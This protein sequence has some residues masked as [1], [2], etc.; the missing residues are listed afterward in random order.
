MKL[1]NE[2]ELDVSVWTIQRHLRRSGLRYKKIPPQIYLTKKHKENRVST[3]S[4][5]VTENYPWEKNR[6]P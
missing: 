2:C 4:T 3:I 1:K 5:W 6:F